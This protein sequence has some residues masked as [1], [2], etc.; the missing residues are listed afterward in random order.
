MSEQNKDWYSLQEVADLF[1]VPLYRVRAAV[2]TLRAT[3]AVVARDRPTDRRVLEVQK[4]SI[5]V[6][7]QALLGE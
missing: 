1:G 2:A 4:E 7:R 5:P 6:L 3:N